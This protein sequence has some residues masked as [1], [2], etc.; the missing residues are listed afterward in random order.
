MGC[1]APGVWA[2]TAA[3]AHIEVVRASAED[4]GGQA[5]G[6]KQERHELRRVQVARQRHKPT[7]ADGCWE[8]G[9]VL[10][11]PATPSLAPWAVIRHPQRVY[12]EGAGRTN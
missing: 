3:M 4:G 9:S 11:G 5:L 6:C 2:V 12:L 8:R 1:L 7:R 10:P